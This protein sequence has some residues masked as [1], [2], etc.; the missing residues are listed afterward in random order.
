VLLGAWRSIRKSTEFLIAVIPFLILFAHSV[1][2]ALGLMASNGEL[3]Y[4]LIV[5]PFWALLA[6]RGE[7]ARGAG[8]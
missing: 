5:A 6:A 3:R 1:I 7:R 2:Y 8:G 4:M